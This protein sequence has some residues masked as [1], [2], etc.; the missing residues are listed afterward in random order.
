MANIKNKNFMKKINISVILIFLILALAGCKYDFILE[1]EAPPVDPSGP[2]I[3]YAQQ[4]QPIFNAG[5]VGCH[6]AGATP[7]NLVSGSSYAAINTSKYI[8]TATPAESGIYKVPA[9]AGTTHR[10]KTYTAS[11]A[12][13]ILGWI[14][15]GAKNN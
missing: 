4:I 13:L 14:Q 12:A 3:S 5:C 15:Q 7:P 8:N 1:E 9:P 10:H 2:E 11:E 6:K